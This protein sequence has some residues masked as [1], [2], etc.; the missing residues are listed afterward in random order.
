MYLKMFFLLPLTQSLSSDSFLNQPCY[1]DSALNQPHPSDSDSF[2]KSRSFDSTLD[3]PRPSDSDSSLIQLHYPSHPSDSSRGQPCSSDSIVQPCPSDSD[4]LL[5]QCPSSDSSVTQPHPSDS[6]SFI[7]FHSSDSTLDQPRPSDSDSSRGQPCSSDS[8][9]QCPSSDS[10]ITQPCCSESSLNHSDSSPI[11]TP[12]TLQD[13]HRCLK[14]PNR[15]WSD[16]SPQPLLSI[17]LC[18]LLSLDSTSKQP[19]VITHC[20]TVNSDLQWSLFVHNRQVTPSTCGALKS[21]PL[22][23]TQDSFSDLLNIVDRL[24]VCVGHPDKHFV[25][26]ASARKG[27]LKSYDGSV[28]ASLDD[29]APVVLNGITY[30]QTIRTT[31]CEWLVHGVKCAS[32]QK[33]RSTLRSAYNCGVKRQ[34]DRHKLPYK[35]EIHDHTGEEKK[36]GENEETCTGC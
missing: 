16:Q 31:S 3:Q 33:Y 10:S 1:S 35:H 29:Y 5:L 34:Y 25:K 28:A 19:L 26:F 11:Q 4:S 12:L 24:H 15:Y 30:M 13:L 14:L 36:D 18:K 21:L 17:K 27:V 6:D 20:V 2:I 32:C 23:L 7:Q 22:Q 9:I 8:I